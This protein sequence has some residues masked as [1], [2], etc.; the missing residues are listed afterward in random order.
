MGKKISRNQIKEEA[1]RIFNI[2]SFR[3]SKAW[4]DKFIKE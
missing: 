2:E 1:I 4:M 3:A